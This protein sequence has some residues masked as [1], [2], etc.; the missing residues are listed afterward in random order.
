[1]KALKMKRIAMKNIC[2]FIGAYF[3]TFSKE[4]SENC[5]IDDFDVTISND[6]ERRLFETFVKGHTEELL[7]EKYD[8]ELGISQYF[9]PILQYYHLSEVLLRIPSYY[10]N[11]PF[12]PKNIFKDNSLYEYFKNHFKPSQRIKH[13]DSSKKTFHEKVLRKDLFVFV[14][15]TC[16]VNVYAHFK[17]RYLKIN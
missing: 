1:M 6:F 4:F 11:F 17:N 7:D 5:R 9:I 10:F 15:E 8:F 2:W 16:H 12:I 14:I 3:F 13:W